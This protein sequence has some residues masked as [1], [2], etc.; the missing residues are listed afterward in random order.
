M[1]MIRQNILCIT[2]DTFYYQDT[3]SKQTS[4]MSTVVTGGEV[5]LDAILTQYLTVAK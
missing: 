1:K 3:V 4:N 5:L 2:S